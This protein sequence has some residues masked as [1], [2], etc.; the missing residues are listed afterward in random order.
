M[1]D[2]G[3]L[4]LYVGATAVLCGGIGVLIAYAWFTGANPAPPS[5]KEVGDL[6]DEV[7][8]LAVQVTEVAEDAAL[9]AMHTKQG[10]ESLSSTIDA[11]TKVFQPLVPTPI[12][13]KKED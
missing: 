1:I 11:L 7:N 13:P 4:F 9:V 8:R 12:D 10:F 6:R 3:V 2:S 5:A